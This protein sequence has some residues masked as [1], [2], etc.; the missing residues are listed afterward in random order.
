LDQYFGS[1][2]SALM[3]DISHAV[4]WDMKTL[5]DGTKFWQIEIWDT[6]ILDDTDFES[7]FGTLGITKY[8]LNLVNIR[9]GY[10]ILLCSDPDT[11]NYLANVF[12][13]VII[14]NEVRYRSIHLRKEYMRELQKTH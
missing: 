7:I 14:W 6:S 3:R 5:P 4:S 8:C 1:V 12:D 10:S 9:D 11:R 13:G 2:Q